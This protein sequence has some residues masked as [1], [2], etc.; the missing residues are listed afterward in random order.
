MQVLRAL[1][2]QVYK[3]CTSYLCGSLYARLGTQWFYFSDN[4]FCILYFFLNTLKK[5]LP[6]LSPFPAARSGVI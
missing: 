2:S 5:S 4:F 3:R 1:F 6:S